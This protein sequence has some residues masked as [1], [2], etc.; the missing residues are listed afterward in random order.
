MQFGRPIGSFRAVKHRL[1]D[2]LV[3]L[4][5]ARSAMLHAVDGPVSGA[6]DAPERAAVAAAYCTEAFSHAAGEMIQLHGG[7]AI[8]WEHDA[9]PVFKRAHA[10][11]ALW[12]QPHT[13][14]ARLAL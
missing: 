6:A 10:L 5:L 12:G 13:H 1:A 8:T 11:G 2:L 9:H 14:R 3:E 7:I 4:E